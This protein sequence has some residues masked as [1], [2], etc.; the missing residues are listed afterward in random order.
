MIT[1]FHDNEMFC[2]KCFLHDT[3]WTGGNSWGIDYCPNCKKQKGIIS[4]E[5]IL[6]KH[7]SYLQKQ[8]AIKLFND[9]WIKERIKKEN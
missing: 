4:S 2:N 8:L 5:T 1:A 3:F 7:M 9:W 6:W